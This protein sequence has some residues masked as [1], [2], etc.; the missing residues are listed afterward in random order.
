MKHKFCDKC[1][2]QTSSPANYCSNCGQKFSNTN[3]M[4]APHIQSEDADQII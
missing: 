2:K 3:N 4:R 1:G